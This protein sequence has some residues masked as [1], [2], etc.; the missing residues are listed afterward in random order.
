MF[1]SVLKSLKERFR[2]S[3]KPLATSGDATNAFRMLFEAHG[4]PCKLVDGWINADCL[5]AQARVSLRQHPKNF[6]AELELEIQTRAGNQI[7][8]MF[9]GIGPTV[10]DAIGDAIKNC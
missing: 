6:L 1:A 3:P 7:L 9:V 5:R 8:E 2:P 4:L 10:H